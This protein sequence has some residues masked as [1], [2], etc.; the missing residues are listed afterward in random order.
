[1]RMLMITLSDCLCRSVPLDSLNLRPVSSQAESTQYLPT[2]SGDLQCFS[3]Y[4]DLSSI[5]PDFDLG[6]LKRNP[7]PDSNDFFGDLYAEFKVNNVVSPLKDL[8]KNASQKC[9]VL[10]DLN[11]EF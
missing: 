2:Q 7:S 5:T 9:N 4:N 6:I 8:F 1:M 10:Y 3:C 11:A